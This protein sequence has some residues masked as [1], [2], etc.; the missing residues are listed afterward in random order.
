MQENCVKAVFHRNIF[1]IMR[2]S[3]NTSHM[4]AKR[5][6]HHNDD[7]GASPDG[8]IQFKYSI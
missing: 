2:K 6:W 3:I 7:M 4:Y 1:V 5:P 8:Y